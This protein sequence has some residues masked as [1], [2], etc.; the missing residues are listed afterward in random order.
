MCQLQGFGDTFDYH[1]FNQ[2]N[3]L[4]GNNFIG[5]KLITRTNTN[6]SET[7]TTMPYTMH[8]DGGVATAGGLL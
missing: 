1:I 3:N 7:Y 5:N 2:C 4:I 8:D 6:I